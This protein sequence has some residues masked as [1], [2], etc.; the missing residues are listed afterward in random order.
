MKGNPFQCNGVICASRGCSSSGL[1]AALGVNQFTNHET[2]E[3][4]LLIQ[5][6]KPIGN[7]M[8]WQVEEQW[9]AQAK[10]LDGFQLQNHLS[11]NSCDLKMQYQ[12]LL[13]LAKTI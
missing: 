5:A 3:L 12:V 13:R 11:L 6:I 9:N 1:S 4:L 8:W 10:T 7:D 2:E